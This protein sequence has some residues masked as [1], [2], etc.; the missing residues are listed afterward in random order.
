MSMNKPEISIIVPVF[1]EH[2]VLPAFFEELSRV[3]NNLNSPYEILFVDD[4]SR[5][6]TF[7]ELLELQKR[8]QTIKVIRFSRN[9]GHQ[10]AM[11]AGLHRAQGRACIIMDGDLQDPPSLIPDMI[12]YWKQGYDVV[13]AKRRLREGEGVF[14][15]FTANVFY[16]IIKK[17]SGVDIPI[18]TGDFRLMDG[19]IV[20]VLNNLPER[21][22]FIRGLVAWMGYRQ[23]GVEF[24][25]PA[26]MA[27]E[28]K[29]SLWK[30]IRFAV[31]GITAF[32]HVPLRLVTLFG[33]VFLMVSILTGV[34]I[35]YVKFVA[36]TEAPGW[37]SLMGIIIFLGSIQLLSLG[38]IGEYLAR[39]FDELKQRPSYLVLDERG[40]ARRNTEQ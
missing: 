3:M 19:K 9:F 28:T 11:T 7:D 1:N 6:G 38:I 2:E 27:G 31:D 5:D 20:E 18:D 33:F 30:M 4:G 26:R 21:N 39:M 8:H 29:F 17:L 35:F 14:K 36:H 34:W 13:Y 22:R 23:I 16:R 37:T 12:E 24:D 32:S 15:K 10:S 25:R 40:F